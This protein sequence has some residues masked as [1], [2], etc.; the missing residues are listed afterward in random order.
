MFGLQNEW[1]EKI[2]EALKVENTR[3]KGHLSSLYYHIH[4]GDE[5]RETLLKIYQTE[6]KGGD[7]G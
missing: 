6:L 2:I 1:N 4:K 7:H 3:L 5:L